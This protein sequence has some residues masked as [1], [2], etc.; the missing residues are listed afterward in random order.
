MGAPWL[1]VASALTYLPAPPNGPDP[2]RCSRA[3]HDRGCPHRAVLPA[4]LT[5]DDGLYGATIRQLQVAGRATGLGARRGYGLVNLLLFCALW[6]LLMLSLALI[7]IRQRQRIR[8]LRRRTQ[9]RASK[10]MA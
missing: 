7:A 9:S 5:S 10:A 2:Q 6:P 4:V 1:L 8:T 3:C